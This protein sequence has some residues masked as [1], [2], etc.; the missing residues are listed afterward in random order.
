MK[1]VLG[2]VHSLAERRSLDLGLAPRTRARE[3][4]LRAYLWSRYWRA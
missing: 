3:S 4:R 1:L 2:P